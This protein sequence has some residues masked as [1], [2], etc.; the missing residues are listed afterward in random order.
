MK[1][2]VHAV[3]LLQACSTTSGGIR[4]CSIFE[5]QGGHWQ[6]KIDLTFSCL[7]NIWHWKMTLK[8][9]ILQYL[10]AYLIILVG[11]KKKKIKTHFLSVVKRS[12]KVNQKWLFSGSSLKTQKIKYQFWN[13]DGQ[14]SILF[15]IF[16]S[17]LQVWFSYY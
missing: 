7:Q 14:T 13:R 17:K 5:F 2:L 11:H 1:L 9:M 4:V 6:L 3:C 15:P 12:V 10:V 8:I 16:N